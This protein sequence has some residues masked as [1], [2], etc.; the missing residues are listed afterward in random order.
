[1]RGVPML[2]KWVL[3]CAVTLLIASLIMC[4]GSGESQSPTGLSPG[5]R[6]TDLS[7]GEAVEVCDWMASLYGGYGRTITCDGGAENVGPTD[8]ASCAVQFTQFKSIDPS[9]SATVGDFQACQQWQV[10]NFCVAT[11]GAVP[12]ACM[13]L[14]N[15]SQC[16]PG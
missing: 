10:Q 8:Q 13:S 7:Q 4:G 15:S 1:V 11:P 6:L 16:S 14:A 9:C 5:D 2:S 3:F 12:Q